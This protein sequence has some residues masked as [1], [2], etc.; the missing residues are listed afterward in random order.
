MPDGVVVCFVGFVELWVA[1][2]CFCT[3]PTHTHPPPF[4]N[5]APHSVISFF[6]Q[7]VDWGQLDYLVIDTPPGT[8]DEH[9]SVVRYLEGCTVDG[10]VVVTTPQVSTY[11][12]TELHVIY[13]S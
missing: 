6:G 13:K 11:C 7:D 9:M 12:Y 1:S 3:P 2:S 4:P 10:A 8:S 5:P